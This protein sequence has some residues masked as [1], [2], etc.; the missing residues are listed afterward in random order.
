MDFRIP[1]ELTALRQSFAAFLDREVRPIEERLQPEVWSYSP[2]R[3]LVHAAARE[4][5]ARSVE[6]GFY[7][8]YMAEEVG[9]MDLST[10]G[11]ALLVE[12]AA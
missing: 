10:L 11:T 8:A 2:D 9:G 1:D 5:V 6:A 4:V 12:D 3:E 7:A